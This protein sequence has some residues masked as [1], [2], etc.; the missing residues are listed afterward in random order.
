[1]AAPI[2]SKAVLISRR[3]NPERYIHL[4]IREEHIARTAAPGQFVMIRGWN[5]GD[6][7]LPRPFDIV[8][9][10]PVK[11]IFRLC[12]KVEGKGT[13]LLSFLKKGSTLYITGPLGKSISE[14]SSQGTALLVRGAGAAAV[15]FLAETLSKLKKPVYTILSASMKK[16]LVCRSLLEQASTELFVATD[17]GSEGYAGNGTNLLDQLVQEGKVG[18]VYTCGSRRFARHVKELDLEGKLKGYVFLEGNMGC[19]MGDCHGCPVKKD[20]SE[21]YFLVCKDG[22]VFRSRDVV[23]E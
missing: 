22:P 18:E 17:D 9:T 2:Y 3:E 19:G 14:F 8:T 21:G 23:I 1:M 4:V 10:D 11:G 12:V 5:T 13:R 6:P 16:R 20:G 15:V 7:I